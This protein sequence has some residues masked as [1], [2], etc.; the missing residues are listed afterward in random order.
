M[1]GRQ[2]GWRLNAVHVVLR[3]LQCLERSIQLVVLGL[4]LFIITILP[5]LLLLHLFLEARHHQLGVLHLR[6]Q[7]LVHS[8]HVPQRLHPVPDDERALRAQHVASSNAGTALAAFVLLVAES[9]TA[10][11]RVE[12]RGLYLLV[13]DG[14]QFLHIDTLCLVVVVQVHLRGAISTARSAEVVDLAIVEVLAFFV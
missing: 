3:F 1:R 4:Q 13:T 2:L 8:L 7:V 14:R 12:C 9:C 11:V 6:C 10:V 5:R